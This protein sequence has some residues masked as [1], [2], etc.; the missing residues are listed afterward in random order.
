ML[1][2]LCDTVPNSASINEKKQNSLALY[3]TRLRGLGK[4]TL[5]STLDLI[6]NT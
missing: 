6:P 3:F 5:L 4:N 1:V 2:Q